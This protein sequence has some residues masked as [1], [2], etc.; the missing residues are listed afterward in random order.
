MNT[1]RK[2]IAMLST[3]VVAA[4]APATGGDLREPP[5]VSLSSGQLR[6]A[7]EDNGVFAYKGIPYAKPP[8][9]TLRWRSPQ[10][11]AAWRGVRDATGFGLRCLTPKGGPLASSAPAGEDCLTANVWTPGPV[12]SA[13]HPVMVWIHGGGFQFGSSQDANTNGS[14]LAAK[15][16]VVVSFNYRLGV[17]GFLAHPDLDREGS[18]SGNYGL[19]DQLA[20]L[21]W[22]KANVARFGGDP[23]NITVFG[24]SAG[25]M[26]VGLL[27]SSPQ[28]HGLFQKAI[29]ESGAFWDSEHGSIATRGEAEARGRALADRLGHGTIKGLRDLPGQQLVTD[30]QWDFHADPVTA[31]FSPSID[32]LVLPLSPAAAF[33]RRRQ[34]RIPLLTGRNGA[35]DFIFRNRALPHASAAQFRAAATELFGADRIAEFLT[36]YPATTDQEATASA[37]ALIGDLAISQQNWAWAQMQA[38]AGSPPVYEYEYRYSSDYSPMPIHGAEIDFVFGT[39]APQRMTRPGTSLTARDREVADQ[40]MSYWTNFARTGNPNGPG[41]PQWP[42]YQPNAPQVIEFAATT[43]AR[44]ERDTARYAFIQTFRQDG[45]FPD[46]WRRLGAGGGV[47]PAGH[48]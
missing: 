46:R 31:A 28:A 25:A 3:A 6:G 23:H 11:A 8:L 29:G 40:I 33:E 47:S 1:M 39:L 9:G 7:T 12:T 27:M 26:S 13:K 43:S 4:A 20:A 14:R 30:T 22:V 21:R 35:E 17:L 2:L 38:G 32:G 42:A 15:G 41:L 18:A 10:P 37:N 16:V 45:R 48:P 19:Q 24:E 36:L 5:T 34:L 44:S